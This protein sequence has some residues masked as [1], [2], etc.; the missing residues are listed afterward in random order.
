MI[1]G[2]SDTARDLTE[3]FGIE[4]PLDRRQIH[5]WNK[6]RTRNRAGEH[7]PS[8]VRRRSALPRQPVLLFDF[9]QV[10]SWA[11]AGVPGPHGKGWRDLVHMP[12]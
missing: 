9:D 11:A 8:P 7:F 1:G 6:R 10:A 2:Y 5:L 4:P 12:E 3:R